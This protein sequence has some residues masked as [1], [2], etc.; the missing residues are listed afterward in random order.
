MKGWIKSIV[1]KYNHQIVVG[2]SEEQSIFSS[3]FLEHSVFHLKTSKN[4]YIMKIISSKICPFVQ[5]VILL[6]EA[7]NIDYNVQHIEAGEMPQWFLNISPKGQVPIL[8]TD[9]NIPLFDS[10]AII[11]YIEDAYPKLQPNASPEQRAIQ[12]AWSYQASRNYLTQCSAQRSPDKESLIK[13]TQ[14]L[15]FIFDQIE[16]Q[17]TD[18]PYFEGDTLG[19]ADIA[20]LVLLHRAKIIEQRSGYDFIGNRPKMK[21]WQKNL[22]ASG[23]AEK[24]V[25]TDFENVFSDFYLSNKSFL[26][27]GETILPE[28]LNATKPS[29][30][31]SKGGCS[32]GDINKVSS[33]EISN[34]P[35]NSCSA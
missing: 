21:R 27:R 6:L 7:K 10:E 18:T 8:I 26:G 28:E 11:E 16:Q 22:L 32:I 4:F 33:E 14:N 13:G 2:V 1:L 29:Y 23:L 15:H 9:N 31:C 17:L 12:R 5:Q 19:I 3:S 34:Q 25:S 35:V 20:W 24:S 30:S